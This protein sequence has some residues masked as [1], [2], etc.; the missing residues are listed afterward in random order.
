M[1]VVLGATAAFM[2]PIATPVNTLVFVAGGYTW[3]DYA[4]VGLPLLL[5]VMA[6]S[7]VIVPLAWPL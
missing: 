4:K 6:V 5:L 7:L 2:T 3:G 1:M